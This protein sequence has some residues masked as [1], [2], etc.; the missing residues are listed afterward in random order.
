MT[1]G[2]LNR[3]VRFE[4]RTTRDD[5]MG[6][7]RG[8]F[9]P[10]FTCWAGFK[11]LKGSETVIAARMAGIQP[12]IIRVRINSETKRISTGWRAVDSDEVKYDIQSIADID[13][14][15]RYFDIMAQAGGGQGDG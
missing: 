12:A 1:A 15:R 5:G 11:M 3:R 9:V 2:E 14:K 13:G 8:A 4:S 10:E 6:N 7:K